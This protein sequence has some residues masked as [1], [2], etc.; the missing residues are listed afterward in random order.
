MRLPEFY[1]E[2][3]LLIRQRILRRR[4]EIADMFV[5]SLRDLPSFLR[6]PNADIT[7]EDVIKYIRDVRRATSGGMSAIVGRTLDDVVAMYRSIM[8]EEV[9][10]NVGRRRSLPHNVI[11]IIV[12]ADNNVIAGKVIV[13]LAKERG[14]GEL[15]LWALRTDF[16]CWESR[17][18]LFECLTLFTQVD[19][20]LLDAP[21]AIVYA[22]FHDVG[23]MRITEIARLFRRTPSHVFKEMERYY[24]KTK[25]EEILER[26]REE[27][28]LLD[29]ELRRRLEEHERAKAEQK[30]AAKPSTEAAAKPAA[31]KAVVKQPAEK[32]AEEKPSAPPAPPRAEAKA[33]QPRQEQA[34]PKAEQKAEQ[35]RPR[36]RRAGGESVIRSFLDRLRSLEKEIEDEELRAV[37]ADLVRRAAANVER[38]Y[39]ASLRYDQSL[40]IE[41]YVRRRLRET[42]SEIR[43][44][45]ELENAETWEELIALACS[46]EDLRLIAGILR[47]ARRLNVIP[48]VLVAAVVHSIFSELRSLPQ[49]KLETAIQKM[50]RGEIRW[51]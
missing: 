8:E 3:A 16:R 7:Y 47:F 43:G 13:D 5:A 48:D 32:K 17:E 22:L 18:T 49:D 2:L 12:D 37:Y 21:E 15:K 50:V 36:A 30:A 10:R 29:E 40:T 41:E 27:R 35:V 25:I 45:V 42:I 28:D 14:F 44:L 38:G 31:E 33:E 24:P 51:T 39:K 11:P 6:R 26:L 19:L 20:V 9:E 34:A 4:F 23:K 46:K 1:E